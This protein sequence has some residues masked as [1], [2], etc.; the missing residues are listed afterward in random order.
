M[1]DQ[2]KKP[3][4]HSSAP[5]K[6]K[7]D[8]FKD[9][10]F[11][12]PKILREPS[13]RQAKLGSKV[14]LRVTAAGR[15][16]PSYQWFH[17]GK[18]I[19]G[20]TFD[21][22]TLNKLRRLNGGAYHCEVKNFIGKAVSRVCMLSFFTQA[23][24]QLVVE[25]Q[26]STLDEGKPFTLKVASPGLNVLKD[27]R[28]YWTFNGMRIKGAHGPEL[29]IESA[30]KKY[31]GVYKAMISTGSGLETSNAAKL[32]VLSGKVPEAEKQSPTKANKIKPGG[33]TEFNADKTNDRALERTA[34]I[35]GY[36]PPIDLKIAPDVKVA[37]VTENWND[38]LFDPEADE[39][40]VE[41]SL[42][43]AP[44]PIPEELL[45]TAVAE[46]GPVSQLD[47]KDLIREVAEVGGASELLEEVA[48]VEEAAPP[49]AGGWDVDVLTQS[50]LK[51]PQAADP[52]PEAPASDPELARKKTA[53]QNL[54]SKLQKPKP[55]KQA[56]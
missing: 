22:L 31:E 44:K 18:K 26:D 49:D 33:V 8:E 42:S 7:S 28:I 34:K 36:A 43:S 16:L 5:K 6:K 1:A 40:G 55:E 25:P 37:P 17:N 15:P 51:R 3:D 13:S 4:L 46:S 41:E 10:V 20:A 38:F 11:E 35:V 30:K 32:S 23:I 56:A 39:E 47:T 29:K 14:V 9:D 50:H 48:V 52:A 12:A 19:S 21:R 24:P 54:L 53:L 45:E 27:F 2:N